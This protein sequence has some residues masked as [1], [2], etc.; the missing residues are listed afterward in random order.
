M[1]DSNASDNTFAPLC[2]LGCCSQWREQF[3]GAQ[4]TGENTVSYIS[5][6]DSSSCHHCSNDIS[7]CALLQVI[8]QVDGGEKGA[9][10]YRVLATLK[11][12]HEF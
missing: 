12:S 4:F 1:V 8:P 7:R 5:Q 3:T 11:F 9:W 2:V 6:P 10:I